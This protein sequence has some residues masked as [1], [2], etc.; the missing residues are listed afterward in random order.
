M[1]IQ[2]IVFNSHINILKMK[3]TLAFDVYGTLI[4]T[5]GVYL[6]LKNLI[7][8]KATSFM[9]L[10][11][12]KQLEYS[13]RR[14]VMN[15]FVDF[16]VCT[17]DALE[18]CCL[19]FNI[20]ISSGQMDA[21]MNTYK[22]LPI[23]DDVEITLQDL[24]KSRYP[25]FA[26]SNGSAHAVSTLLENADIAHFFNGVVSVEDVRMFKPSPLVYEHFNNHTHSLKSDSWLISGNPFDIIGAISYGMRAVW[27]Q[28]SPEAIFDP[29]DLQ[30]TATIS[31]LNE[32]P[33]IL[34]K[35]NS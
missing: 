27:V 15:A 21:L 24:Q 2:K 31:H 12:S 35:F 10:W 4:D 34:D 5:S 11:R 3:Y 30:P 29:W 20:N 26:L 7:G 28:R 18:Y 25:L 8:E 19:S 14:G 33:S 22:V 1:I 17:K 32:L 16:S 6:S 13:F 23:F 9:D